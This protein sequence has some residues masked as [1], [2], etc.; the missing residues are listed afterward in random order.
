MTSFAFNKFDN[1]MFAAKPPNYADELGGGGVSGLRD[2][3]DKYFLPALKRKQGQSTIED[4]FLSQTEKPGALFGAADTAAKGY[5]SQLF[6]PGGEI[7]SLIGSARGDT[8]SKGFA[9]SSAE[10]SVN[11][12]LRAGTQRV[13]DVFAQNAGQLEQSRYTALTGAYN[14]REQS[15]RDLIESL[16]TGVAS[17][18]QLNL[19][20]H[21]PRQKFLGIF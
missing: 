14:E 13:G 10:G 7:A 12:I 5:A 1:S 15:M 20:K 21:P 8:I 3:L 9:P 19:A 17:S 2:I 4:A 18:E 16:F 11:S 6:A